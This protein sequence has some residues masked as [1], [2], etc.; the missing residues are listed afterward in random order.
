[1]IVEETTRYMATWGDAV[2]PLTLSMFMENFILRTPLAVSWDQKHSRVSRR[3][4]GWHVVR[5]GRLSKASSSVF[6]HLPTPCTLRRN[7]AHRALEA[8]F[9]D[10]M[11]KRRAAGADDM[12]HTDLIETMLTVLMKNGALVSDDVGAHMLIFLLFASQRTTS[13]TGAWLSLYLAHHPHYQQLCVAEQREVFG[14]DLA[15]LNYPSLKEL[16]MLDQCAKEALRLRPPFSMLARKAMTDLAYKSYVIPKGSIVVICP[17]VAHLI[18]ECTK[19]PLVFRP[20]RFALPTPVETATSADCNV[21]AGSSEHQ[22]SPSA[23]ANP[24]PSSMYGRG[25]CVFANQDNHEYP[26][27]H[28]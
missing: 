13:A 5:L 15:P 27:A 23:V 12:K 8:I 19:D 17:G 3:K 6:P 26:V 1:M 24:V 14:I 7:R 4:S 16:R 21:A 10:I 11:R 9:V 20:E 22:G 2:A 25:I 18:A 28:V